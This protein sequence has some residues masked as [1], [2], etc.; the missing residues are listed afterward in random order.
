MLFRSG[1]TAVLQRSGLGLT[2]PLGQRASANVV[3]PVYGV[4]PN[5]PAGPKDP[6]LQMCY[7][8]G[9]EGVLLRETYFHYPGSIAVSLPGWFEENMARMQDYAHLSCIGVVVPTGPHGNVGNGGHL[10][11]ALND[12]E[13]AR[14]KQGVVEAANDLFGAGAVRVHLAS[15]D[16]ISFEVAQRADLPALLDAAIQ[17]QGDLNLATAHPQGGNAIST[18]PDIAVVD[19]DFQVHGV[20]GLFVADASLFPAACGVNPM[21]T[22]MALAHLAATS[23]N[24][25]VA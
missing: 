18:T 8:A 25:F 21:L 2:L 22:T 24:E 16:P 15:K 5:P 4:F 17:D 10:Y 3:T 14:M 11:L 23:V 12:D 6:G 13:F 20:Q 9:Q 7:F 19:S 1:S